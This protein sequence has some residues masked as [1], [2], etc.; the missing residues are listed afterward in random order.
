MTLANS[1][2]S[3]PQCAVCRPRCDRDPG[4]LRLGGPPGRAG[5]LTFLKSAVK[6]TRVPSGLRSS[7]LM[8]SA[9]LS[10]CRLSSVTWPSGSRTRTRSSAGAPAPSSGTSSGSSSSS[11]RRAVGTSQPPGGR[12]PGGRRAP[13]PRRA[14]CGR[15]EAL[16]NFARS[17]WLVRGA[18]ERLPGELGRGAPRR[19]ADARGLRSAARPPAAPRRTR[20][21]GPPARRPSAADPRPQTPARRACL[22]LF[23]QSHPPSLPSENRNHQDLP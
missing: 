2:P 18:R 23:I 14:A 21:S 20:R 5:C 11:A 22:A 7:R 3:G 15:G 4:A 13:R 1:R 12:I 8:L 6:E 16:P 19:G 10:A 9:S 17:W